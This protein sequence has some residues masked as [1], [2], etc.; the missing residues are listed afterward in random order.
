M[1][2][3]V[4]DTWRRTVAAG[5][6]AGVVLA[7]G[8][9]IGRAQL[10]PVCVAPPSGMVAWWPGDGNTLDIVGGD[11][12]AWVGSPSY[13]TGEVGQAFSFAGASYV[14]APSTAALSPAAAIT[15]DA[16]INTTATNATAR[17]VDKITAGGGDGYLLDLLRGRV[18][19]LIDGNSVTGATTLQP[20]VTYHVAG[21][22]DGS[23]LTVYVNGVSDGTQAFS[24]AIPTNS[25]P[26]RI[27]A[28]STG[29]G[30]LFRGW[31]DEV[32]IF[33]RALS[34]SE[35]Q[36]I[37]D[38]LGAGKCKPQPIPV[39]SRPVLLGLGLLVVAAGLLALRR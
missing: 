23:A 29:A 28:D 19:L 36:A 27:G 8:V 7:V 18:R 21:T 10:Q 31:I 15:I 3:A 22:Y 32:E 16:W 24:G 35:I 25:L 17:I 14:Q 26:V 13:A 5:I 34:L 4:H 12:G 37:H 33:S 38:A 30:N 2:D 6:V 9:G 11:T 20:G 39:S 1:R